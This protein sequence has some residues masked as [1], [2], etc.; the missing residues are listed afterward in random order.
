MVLL[1]AE[2]AH[3]SSLALQQAYLSAPP[4]MRL[5]S[6][7]HQS[8]TRAQKAIKHAEH[9]VALLG[10]LPVEAPASVRSLA[11]AKVNVLLLT[12]ARAF[13][14]EQYDEALPGYVVARAMLQL[15]AKGEPNPRDEATAL[16]WIDDEVDP[17]VR[18]CAYKLGRREAHDVEGIVVEFADDLPELLTDLEAQDVYGS[19]EAWAGESA[20]SKPK[21]SQVV[22]LGREVEFRNADVVGVMKEVEVALGKLAVY[23][24]GATTTS[25]AAAPPKK[26]GKI[27]A[28]DKA[29][30]ALG[31]AYEK[32]REI[33]A[34]SQVG[35]S[36]FFSHSLSFRGT[37][38]LVLRVS[39]S[40]S[41]AS[42]SAAPAG[43]SDSLSLLQ[44]YLLHTLLMHRISR[45]LLLISALLRPFSASAKATG[46]SSQ[47]RTSSLPSDL[48]KTLPAVLKL[49]D[50][51]IKGFEGIREL[52][53]VE[54]DGEIA[55]AVEAKLGFFRAKRIHRLAQL[56]LYLSS[57]P[58]PPP[59]SNADE[60][61]EPT[62]PV[63]G[64]TKSLLLL[65]RASLLLRQT[66]SLPLAYPPSD[67]VPLTVEG[68]L[69]PLEREIAELEMEAKT[70]LFREVGGVGEK[71]GGGELK[72]VALLYVGET[73]LK[74]QATKGTKAAPAVVASSK[75]KAVEKPAATVPAGVAPAAVAQDAEEE[76]EDERND[77]E[78]EHYEDSSDEEEDDEPRPKGWLSGW[79]S[80]K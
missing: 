53:A 15:L 1:E 80:R 74:P 40:G 54:A 47:R 71:E 52:S 34:Q 79:F 9:L 2:R 48:G 59:A 72:D 76:D 45:D 51:V 60:Q 58:T 4:A 26:G 7:L 38:T 46:S 35:R 63:S 25:A 20:S 23:E 12:S 14:K 31:N 78:A 29:L 57:S 19:L 77:G 8:H 28:F 67:R 22:W 37:D 39:Q 50:A 56:H 62:K 41:S 70:R 75:A 68:D 61:D 5:K 6:T 17:R 44:D 27:K 13:A 30:V 36:H 16:S 65:S 24:Q 3:T 73:A 11:Q 43:T 69:A 42:M 32:V 10:S 21:A 55:E 64:T 49:Y 66:H 33:R 18:F